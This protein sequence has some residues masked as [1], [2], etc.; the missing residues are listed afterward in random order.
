M[1]EADRKRRAGLPLTAQDEAWCGRFDSQRESQRQYMER[2]RADPDLRAQDRMRTREFQRKARA[3]PIEHER[4]KERARMGYRDRVGGERKL[5]PAAR[6]R[7]YRTTLTPEERLD[8]APLAAWLR[9]TFPNIPVPTLADILHTPERD[10]RSWLEVHDR[11]TVALPVVDRLFVSIG[12]P[13]LL[14]ALYPL[15]AAS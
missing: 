5:P 7:H 9:E 13:D 15:E 11:E 14:N 8:P 2:R 10:L 3:D 1:V 4:I 6:F 12:R